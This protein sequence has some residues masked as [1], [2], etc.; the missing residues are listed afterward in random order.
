MSS[1]CSVLFC[2]N[3]TDIQCSGVIVGAAEGTYCGKGKVCIQGQ[4]AK[5]PLAELTGSSQ[6]SASNR[7]DCLLSENVLISSVYYE[8]F[9]QK[10]FGFTFNKA[11]MTCQE[12]LDYAQNDL[13]HA[14]SVYCENAKF[15]KICCNTCKSIII[16]GLI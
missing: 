6:K 3:T 11:Q 1:I 14:A 16:F 12:I 4:C 9:M 8:R 5:N 2:R 7:D 10:K 13:N 15:R